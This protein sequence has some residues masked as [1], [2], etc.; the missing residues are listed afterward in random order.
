MVHGLTPETIFDIGAYSHYINIWQL[1]I[2]RELLNVPGDTAARL[3]DF[4]PVPR[5]SMMSN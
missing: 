4:L 3:A 2:P 1:R 5:E